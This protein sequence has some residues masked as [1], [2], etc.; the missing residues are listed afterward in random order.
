MA[1]RPLPS[2]TRERLKIINRW[3]KNL[4]TR[5]PFV[6]KWLNHKG[7][8]NL[9][10]AAENRSPEAAAALSRSASHHPDNKIRVG[11]QL[12]LKNLR[13]PSC[14]TAIWQVWTGNRSPDLLVLLT[15][16][17]I[18]AS[19][20]PLV[21]V[22]SFIKTGRQIYLRRA[23]KDDALAL[24]DALKDPDPHIQD[25]AIE[26]LNTMSS[27]VGINAICQQWLFERTNTLQQIILQGGHHATE[28]PEA[29]VFTALLHAR[30]DWLTQGNREIVRPLISALKDRNEQ[31]AHLAE[32][33]L[34]N[35]NNPEAI[36]EFCSICFETRNPMLENILIAAGYSP[37]DLL[38]VKI[39]CLL[40][41]NRMPDSFSQPV[42][43]LLVLLK[44]LADPDNSIRITAEQ[45]LN[46]LT[47]EKMVDGLCQIVIDSAHPG[48]S[49]IC[50]Q[51]AYYPHD[52]TIKAMFLFIRGDWDEYSK[53]DFDRRIL[54]SAYTHANPDLRRR[55]TT[56]IQ[57]SGRIDFLE[58]LSGRQQIKLS[59][60]SSQETQL[61]YNMFTFQNQW[62]K[63]WELAQTAT[64][65]WSVR[66]IRRLVEAGYRPAT[67]E[68]AYLFDRLAGLAAK[69]VATNS[70][71]MQ[72]EIL[73]AIRCAVLKV[74]GRVND[75]A[76]S[77]DLHKLAIG[78]GNRKVIIWDLQTGKIQQV[79][80]GFNRS[81][82]LVEY[83]SGDTL[84]ISEKT[85]S[86][87]EC[88]LYRQEGESAIPMG[89]HS[90]SITV[91]QPYMENRAI[92][93][94]KD[95]HLRIYN[96]SGSIVSETALSYWPRCH[97][98]DHESQT[99]ALCTSRPYFYSMPGFEPQKYS[100]ITT[101]VNQKTN[102]VITNASFNGQSRILT[103]HGN[104]SVF[105]SIQRDGQ[106]W[107]RTRVAQIKSPVRAVFEIQNHNQILVADAGGV[108]R[109]YTAL[110]F[111]ETGLLQESPP[112]TTVA[113][114]PDAA[115]MAVGLHTNG[116]A[117]Y[118]L[119]CLDLP[120]LVEK[121]L[122]AYKNADLS[123]I[124][125]LQQYT[126]PEPIMNGLRYVV[127]LL[128]H[129][130]RFDIHVSE[131]ATIQPGE[132][133]IVVD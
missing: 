46:N 49:Q 29:L 36:Q 30:P 106:R 55:I 73:P 84:W 111:Q 27:Q 78:T 83:S 56:Q 77:P 102:S 85:I 53:I 34:R 17:G 2:S 94:A 7:L 125:T 43:A 95:Q 13:H 4:N 117:L 92:T 107:E 118:D 104:G 87:A 97:T 86:T 109:F 69:E 42:D 47:N 100:L 105:L 72:V 101:D 115:F 79:L 121:P 65:E 88:R 62:D 113:L 75:F 41:L 44:S 114:S 20:P 123:M 58:I 33:T 22:L 16:K 120:Q 127:E 25:T 131:L 21:R 40:K 31:I 74:S 48:A 38:D 89:R 60:F 6:R 35:L 126:F 1:P 122:S 99:L 64:L 70:T 98:F 112:I 18:T 12:V 119:R 67:S 14:V 19:R 108:I 116:L 54:R 9:T 90:G 11:C 15:E 61:Q 32:F 45:Y 3:E 80:G 51:Q 71:D 96:Q 28:P 103:G 57:E 59:E 10:Y 124:L 26:I 91:L 37:I 5:I 110:D 8:K 132:F 52:P 128:H 81:I 66:I 24:L 23:R 130:F 68:Q 129:R 63:L 50:Q 93:V 39:Y 82:G 133:D 76:F